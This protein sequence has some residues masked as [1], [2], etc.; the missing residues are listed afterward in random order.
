[1]VQTVLF[2]EFAVLFRQAP[3]LTSQKMRQAAASKMRTAQ[4]WRLI[5]AGK[6]PQ[7]QDPEAAYA[8]IGRTAVPPGTTEHCKQLTALPRS[9]GNTLWALTPPTVVGNHLRG[10]GLGMGSVGPSLLTEIP[11]AI[12]SPAASRLRRAPIEMDAVVAISLTVWHTG[13]ARRLIV[14][15]T[16]RVADGLQTRLV[17]VVYAEVHPVSCW[18]G[19][20]IAV[21]REKGGGAW[22]RCKHAGDGPKK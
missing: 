22:S 21:E 11:A 8:L 1:M 4:Q 17:Y 10:L 5:P 9:I 18:V 19:S 15:A 13:G 2:R 12:G 20:K 3:W 16:A 7:G 14:G 6:Q